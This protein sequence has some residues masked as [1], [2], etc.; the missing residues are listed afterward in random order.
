MKN[1]GKG[2]AIITALLLT[3]MESQVSGVIIGEI[4]M[5]VMIELSI[6]KNGIVEWTYHGPL[7]E[8]I[9]ESDDTFWDFD[10]FEITNTDHEKFG[11][12]TEWKIRNDPILAPEVVHQRLDDEEIIKEYEHYEDF[13]YGRQYEG[14]ERNQGERLWILISLVKGL[15]MAMMM[16]PF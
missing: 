12:Y 9:P 10:K 16:R 13:D 8:E 6:Q 7:S 14:Y 5:N 11:K 3:S 4:T 2:V 15:P 1:R